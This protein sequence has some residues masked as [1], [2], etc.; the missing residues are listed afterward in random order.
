MPQQYDPYNQNYYTQPDKGKSVKGSKFSLISISTIILAI[1]F[2]FVIVKF[3]I[4]SAILAILGLIFGI[5]AVKKGNSLKGLAIFSIILSLIFLIFMISIFAIF[6]YP[7]WKE[8]KLQEQ[9]KL[10]QIRENERNF[11]MAISSLDPTYC[12][13]IFPWSFSY[14]F[15]DLMRDPDYTQT[16]KCYSEVAIGLKDLKICNLPFEVGVRG[17]YYVDNDELMPFTEEGNYVMID[18]YHQFILTNTDYNCEL[19]SG[20]FRNTGKPINKKDFCYS[21]FGLLKSKNYCSNI[22]NPEMKN[23]CLNE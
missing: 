1:I 7:D 9:E 4:L 23:T 18:C 6:T 19:M 11:N 12:S 8:I 16:A 10:E 20:E 15:E 2:R 13:K 3:F 5:I 22:I 17:W 14:V 21:V